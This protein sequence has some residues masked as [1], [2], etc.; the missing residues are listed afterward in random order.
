M[1]KVSAVPTMTI[2]AVTARRAEEE[3]PLPTRKNK[4]K[5]VITAAVKLITKEYFKRSV[6]H[7]APLLSLLFN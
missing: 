7:R 6:P 1:K 2:N 5:P 3:S 4:I